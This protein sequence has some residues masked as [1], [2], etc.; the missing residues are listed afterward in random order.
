MALSW[1]EWIFVIVWI[2]NFIISLIY[3]LWGI[4]VYVPAHEAAEPDD[5]NYEQDFDNR[6]AYIIRFIIMVLCPVVGPLFF[7]FGYLLY[8]TVFRQNVD[9]ADV[10]FSKERVKMRMKADEERE[11]DMVPLEE[12]L[13]ITNKKNL[14]KLM[15]NVIKGDIR[16]SMSSL[17][18]ALNS[19]DSETSHYAASV[20]RDELNEFRTRV[21]EI[22]G[23]IEEESEEETEYERLLIDYMN[24]VLRQHVFSTM[25]QKRFVHILGDAA[26]KLFEKKPEEIT[27]DQYEEICL[28]YIELDEFEAAEK[29]CLRLAESHPDTLAAYTCRL[30]LYF[31]NN[32]KENFF[33][34]MKELKQSDVLID[35]ETLELIRVF[36]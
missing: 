8:I 16:N 26:E 36:S 17:T 6:R 12:A 35:K 7:L 1:E 2:I 19:D 34:V 13:A 23:Q 5:P 27:G 22:S 15:L 32:D 28:R 9:L 3:L 21:Q 24:S 14:R 18:L 10:V 25:E 20:L 33:T 11:R 30:K 4:L 31:K 29:W